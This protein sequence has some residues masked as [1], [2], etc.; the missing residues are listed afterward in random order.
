MALTAPLSGY[1]KKTFIIYAV[2]CLGLAAWLYYDGHYN[3]RFIDKHTGK[4]GLPDKTLVVHLK[5]PPYLIGAAALLGLYLFTILSRKVV[6][7][8]SRFVINDKISI[9]Y[10][11][12]QKIDK[13]H[14]SSKGFFIITYRGPDG[15]D[16]DRKISDRDY[17]NLGPILDHI[18]AKIS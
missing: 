7:E 17:D 9:A 8:D 16:I 15:K 2:L 1:K 14:F 4:D 5:G 12:I 3:Q 11:T 6:A 10:D 13:T 18:V